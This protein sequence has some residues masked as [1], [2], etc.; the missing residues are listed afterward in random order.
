MMKDISLDP[1]VYSFRI[2]GAGDAP[3]LAGLVN[4]IIDEGDKTAITSH[5]D[6]DTF[7]EW[8]I[9]GVHCRSCVLVEKCGVGPV[10]FQATERF[11]ELPEGWADVAT[12]LT[13]DVRGLGLGKAL[14]A[15]TLRLAPVSC[16]RVLRAVIRSGNTEAIA[17]YGSCG[18][19]PLTGH[20]APV[21]ATGKVVLTRNV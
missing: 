14:F 1:K 15:R 18:F 7:R 20:N 19:K 13:S 17:F 12:F 5:F 4:S 16:V 10:G 2:A 8:F 11:L 21:A 6:A 3:S 9:T